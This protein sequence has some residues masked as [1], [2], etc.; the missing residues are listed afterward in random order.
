[1]HVLKSYGINMSNTIQSL[2]YQSM[3]QSDDIKRH[4]LVVLR[5]HTTT[6]PSETVLITMMYRYVRMPNYHIFIID[7]VT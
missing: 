7:T 4:P 5:S 6:K 3:I 2:F 1:M